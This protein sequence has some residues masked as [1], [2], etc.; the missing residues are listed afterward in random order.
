L[1]GAGWRPGPDGIRAKGTRRLAIDLVQYGGNPMSLL[2]MLVTN[3]VRNYGGWGL[4]E[5]DAAVAK[6]RTEFDTARRDDALKQVHTI[7]ARDVPFTFSVSQ[8]WATV[9]N[10][11][12]AGYTPTSMVHHFIVTKDTAP[13]SKR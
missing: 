13:S 11:A 5:L 2:P 7:M 1:G 10:D 3:N 4:P 9:T 8:S 6:A 12:F